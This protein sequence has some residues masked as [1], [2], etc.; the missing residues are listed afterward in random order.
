MH[1]TSQ[2]DARTRTPKQQ[3]ALNITAALRVAGPDSA[4]KP[5]KLRQVDVMRRTGVSRTTLRPLLETTETGQRNPDFTTLHKMAQAIGVPLAFLLM[6]PDDW[7]V[8]IK[9]IGAFTD[10]QAAAR[11]LVT[12]ALGSPELAEAVLKR[13]KIH[14]ERPPLG[15]A[16]DPQEIQRLD[17]RNE[18]RRRCS[19]VM[20]ALA[21]PAARG[22]LRSLVDLTSLA[23]ALANAMTPYNPTPDNYDRD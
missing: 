8:L 6:T 18:W 1:E 13:C 20:A 9:A 23:A 11:E 2:S 3:L 4:G 5:S 19:F 15:V 22:E 17:A 10:H 12:D 14:P 16:Y 7:R 21:Q